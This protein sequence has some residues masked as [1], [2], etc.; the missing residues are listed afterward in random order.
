MNCSGFYAPYI[1]ARDVGDHRMIRISKLAVPSLL[2]AAACAG[3]SSTTPPPGTSGP[4]RPITPNQ[5]TATT[6]GMT[7]MSADARTGA[8]RLLR[9]L[10][11][12]AAAA[13]MSPGEAA[14]DHIAALA[15]LWVKH[16]PAMALSET[17]VQ[18]LRNGASVVKLAQHI[19]GVPVLNGELRVMLNPNGDLA[20]VS[21]TLL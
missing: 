5:Q 16:A 8:P 21:G 10:P 19:D 18:R 2:F 7:I 3:S 1:F 4:G 17:G 20:A 6:L 15:P 14:R 11:P 12:R 9:A 13:G